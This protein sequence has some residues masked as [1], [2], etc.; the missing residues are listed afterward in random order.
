[1]VIHQMVDGLTLIT[2]PSKPP[3]GLRQEPQNFWLRL[4]ADLREYRERT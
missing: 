1:M 3:V 2:L 4:V